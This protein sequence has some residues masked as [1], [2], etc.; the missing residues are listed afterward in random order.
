MCA[1]STTATLVRTLKP[2]M[3]LKP[4]SLA[5]NVNPSLLANGTRVQN[6]ALQDVAKS[7]M[8]GWVSKPAAPTPCP[9]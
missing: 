3:T 7:A 1:L 5:T 6:V 2:V 9:L 8:M 4:Q